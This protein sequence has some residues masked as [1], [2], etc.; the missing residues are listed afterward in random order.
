M[1]IPDSGIGLGSPPSFA[2]DKIL[3]DLV[4]GMKNGE[5]TTI[6]VALQVIVE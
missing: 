2:S 6:V 1:Y 4:R 3:S 5:W